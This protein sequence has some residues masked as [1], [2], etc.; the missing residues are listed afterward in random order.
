MCLQLLVSA[1]DSGAP[2]NEVQETVTI[3][4]ERNLNTPVFNPIT[5][6]DTVFDYEPIGSSVL[7]VNASDADTTSPERLFMFDIVSTVP[8]TSVAMFAIHP[9]TG[10]ITINR[11]L[12]LESSNIYRVGTHRHWLMSD[13]IGNNIKQFV[14]IV[15]M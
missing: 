5:Y 10:L 15:I 9:A 11:Q 12:T 1:Y 2:Q 14:L 7:F 13:Y 8:S 6:T 3:T 4:V